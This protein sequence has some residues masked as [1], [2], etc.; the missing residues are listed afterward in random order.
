[1]G[2]LGSGGYYRFGKKDRAEDCL[3]LDVRRW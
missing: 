1:M 3:I 2:G